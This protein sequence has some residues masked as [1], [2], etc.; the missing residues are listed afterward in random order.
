[1]SPSE[2]AKTQHWPINY[3]SLGHPDSSVVRKVHAPIRV[4]CDFFLSVASYSSPKGPNIFISFYLNPETQ[5]CGLG[6]V[7]QIKGPLF[8]AFVIF[9][10]KY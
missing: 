10:V 8:R 3:L 6:T 9:S 7:F 2:L 5:S 4:F 1:M